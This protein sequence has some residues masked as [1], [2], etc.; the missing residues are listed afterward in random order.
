MVHGA[1]ICRL[2]SREVNWED[3]KGELQ[4]TLPSPDLPRLL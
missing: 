2:P 1:A 3:V 4:L